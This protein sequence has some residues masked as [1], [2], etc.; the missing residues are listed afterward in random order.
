[1]WAR[2]N[3]KGNRRI[4]EGTLKCDNLDEKQNQGNLACLTDNFN[5]L[6]YK[7]LLKRK[8]T[9]KSWNL[10]GKFGAYIARNSSY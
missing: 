9:L 10:E 1:M 5:K 7:Y 8:V 3:I 4:P 2:T 6:K